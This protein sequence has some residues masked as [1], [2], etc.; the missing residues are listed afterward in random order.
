MKLTD[1][2]NCADNEIRLTFF[3]TQAYKSLPKTM[4]H[5]VLLDIRDFNQFISAL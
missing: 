1:L 5:F 4:R 3:K 2:V